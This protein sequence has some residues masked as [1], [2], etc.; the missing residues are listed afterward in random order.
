MKIGVVGAGAMGSVYAALLARGGHEVWAVD[1]WQEHIQAIRTHGLRVEGASGDHTVPVHATTDP[2]GVG[3]CELVVIA[4]K[5]MDVAKAAESAKALLGPD[6]PV[7]TIQNGLGSGETV[8]GVLGDRVVIGVAG[9]FGG[10][11]LAPGHARHEG[12]E[13]IRLG[14]IDG[15]ATPRLERIAEAW[16]AGGFKVRT[17]DD[18]H[19][20]IWEK[21]I[22]NAAFS[23]VCALTGLLVGQVVENEDTFAVSASLAQESYAVAR[24]KGIR[25][26]VGDPVAYVRDFALKIPEGRPSM[27]QDLEAGRRCEIDAING[28]V[29]RTGREVGIATPVN[30][31]C[32]ALVKGRE[33]ALGIR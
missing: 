27:R 23:P 26:E 1:R 11:I 18:I 5:A 22:C 29:A 12:M 15:P 24:A 21:L 13:L 10:R 6:T 17:F 28:G 25:L 3:P 20:L 9:G 7:L 2:G 14:E 19:Q 4:T 8:R 33:I 16:R 31:T 32:V 30:D